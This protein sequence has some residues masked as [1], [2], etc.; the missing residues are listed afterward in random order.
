MKVPQKINSHDYISKTYREGQPL[1]I[2]T[3][4]LKRNFTHVHFSNK[5]KPL[6]IGPY[7][8]IERLT[9]VTYELLSHNGSTVQVHRNHLISYYPKEPLL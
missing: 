4:D 2:G 1:P 9:D 7:K 6:R 5:L 8:I 3:F